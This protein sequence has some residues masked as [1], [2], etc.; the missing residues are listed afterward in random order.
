MKEPDIFNGKLNDFGTDL[1]NRYVHD[2]VARYNYPWDEAELRQLGQVSMF[3]STAKVA[4]RTKPEERSAHEHVL[5]KIYDA[6]M[7]L[8]GAST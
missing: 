6:I 7:E 5:I 2:A 8:E 3:I 1:T 4:L